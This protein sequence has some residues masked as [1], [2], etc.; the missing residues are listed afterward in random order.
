MPPPPVPWSAPRCPESSLGQIPTDASTS[1]SPQSKVV[2]YQPGVRIEVTGLVNLSSAVSSGTQ[3]FTRVA[4]SYKFHSG[5]ET[6]LEPSSR[7][8]CLYQ[9]GTG[10]SKLS[11]RYVVSPSIVFEPVEPSERHRS[12]SSCSSLR[13]GRGCQTLGDAGGSVT[14][15]T[16]ERADVPA[17]WSGDPATVVVKR[18]APTDLGFVLPSALSFL[19]GINLSA[20]GAPFTAPVTLSIP[21]PAQF[22]ADGQVLIARV[23]EVGRDEP[24]RARRD[25]AAWPA[26][27]SSRR[28]RSE[29]NPLAFEGARGEGRYLFLRPASPVGFAVGLVRATNNDP[30]AGALVSTDTLPLFALSRASGQYVAAAST[31]AV[32]CWRRTRPATTPAP[33]RARFLALTACSPWT[34]A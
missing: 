9:A 2:F 10:P 3:V 24:T 11:A 6:H 8:S 22:P 33:R 31:G 15:E 20:S 13:P 1:V 16:G 29:P 30:F 19:G 18:I 4:E 5:L 23:A 34:S 28:Q 25:R 12:R 14:A 26:I 21:K 7:I 32:P 17:Q 27:A